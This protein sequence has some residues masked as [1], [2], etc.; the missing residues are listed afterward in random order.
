MVMDFSLG[1][2]VLDLSSLL[3]DI[4]PSEIADYLQVTSASVDGVASA[5]LNIS[6]TGDIASG[7][8]QVILVKGLSVSDI[9]SMLAGPDPSLIV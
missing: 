1:T 5:Q 6:S 2:D 4:T 3:G 8:D 7:A 9:N